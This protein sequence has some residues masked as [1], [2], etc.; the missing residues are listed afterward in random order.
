[1]ITIGIG[2]LKRFWKTNWTPTLIKLFCMLAYNNSSN[3]ATHLR[4]FAGAAPESFA[5]YNSLIHEEYHG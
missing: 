2:E 5:V 4:C 1:M 3:I